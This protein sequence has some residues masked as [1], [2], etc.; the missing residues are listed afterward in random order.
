M[1]VLLERARSYPQPAAVADNWGRIW[2][3]T[4]KFRR[5]RSNIKIL[6]EPIN[7]ASHKTGIKDPTGRFERHE[8][9]TKVCDSVICYRAYDSQ[10]GLEVSW[11]E[12]IFPETATKRDIE[13]T[14]ELM[15]R[16]K[17][18]KHPNMN[19]L[20]HFWVL[21]ES[22]RFF[23]ITESISGRS[24]YE[25]VACD[26]QGIRPRLLSK[27]FVPVLQ[28]LQ[29]L[30]SQPSPIVHNRVRTSTIFVKPTSG[31]V[32]IASMLFT[33][34]LLFRDAL[35]ITI[36]P[37][38]PPE[39]LYCDY[40]PYSDIWRFGIA[41]LSAATKSQP[42]SECKSPAEL[43]HKLMNYQPPACLEQITDRLLLDMVTSCLTQP[44]LRPT[45]A[46]LLS[47]PFF[48][49]GCS[50]DDTTSRSEKASDD[51]IVVIFSG[52]P[53]RSDQQLP[54]VSPGMGLESSGEHSTS[55]PFLPTKQR[56]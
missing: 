2:G 56:Q 46:S 43:L 37:D 27:W 13:G 19:S 9:F 28:V 33:Q 17:K 34:K 6:M 24:V 1:K 23:Y 5:K 12:A 54:S 32:K 47:H 10:T 30:H 41:V 53:T 55:S 3:S 50:E 26:S 44:K 45:A 36:E 40:G 31:A 15:E 18:M 7:A 22:K 21:E 52:K 51:G 35:A 4:S 8:D 25:H 39:F 42:Y 11:H 38:T 48:G 14:I 20:L 49:K 29:F 16:V